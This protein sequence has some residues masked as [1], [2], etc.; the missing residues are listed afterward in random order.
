MKINKRLNQ[1]P[2]WADTN[3]EAYSLPAS[4]SLPHFPIPS[5]GH[6]FL[7][8]PP[9]FRVVLGQASDQ[10]RPTKLTEGSEEPP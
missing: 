3:A 1:I 5:P 4:A 10:I 7:R 9:P 2:E 6:T 8:P